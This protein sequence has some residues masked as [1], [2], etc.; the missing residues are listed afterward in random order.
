VERTWANDLA[1]R[2]GDRVRLFGWVHRI[3]RLSR[4][5]FVI[6]RD[7]TE[8]AQIV[9]ADTAILEDLKLTEETV[10]MVEGQ[11]V[12]NAQA[13]NGVEVHDPMIS[14]LARPSEPPPVDLYRPRLRAQLPTILDHA[15]VTLRHLRHRAYFKVAAAS[16]SG[17]RRT[18]VDERFTEIHTPKM[19]ASA[20]ESGADVFAIDYFGRGAYL[21]QSPQFYKQIMVGVF[22]RVFETG[23]VFRAEPHDTPRHLSEY[24][25]LDA[26]LGFIGDHRNVMTVVRSVCAGMM[27]AINELG[28]DTM[29]QLD[30]QLPTVLEE[31]P[32]VHF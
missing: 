8:L 22:E 12:A 9:I 24:V 21:A 13:P 19:V 5:A 17:F 7:A 4:V 20:T 15:P 25:S 14:I 16:V 3:R 10:I 1:E 31:I 11:V 29:T 26:E 2:T 6:L 27:D 30:L 32:A 23:P 18:L 28:R